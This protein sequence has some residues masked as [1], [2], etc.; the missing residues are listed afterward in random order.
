[1]A[2][3]F[4]EKPHARSLAQPRLRFDLRDRSI[5]LVAEAVEASVLGGLVL[6]DRVRRAGITARQMLDSRPARG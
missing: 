6:A 1:V 2:G 4:I 3:A 5:P